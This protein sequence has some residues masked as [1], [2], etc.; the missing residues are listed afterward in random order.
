MD[1]NPIQRDRLLSASRIPA[2]VWPRD[3]VID[4]E[5]P[6][7]GDGDGDGAGGVWELPVLPRSEPCWEPRA[8]TPRPRTPLWWVGSIGGGGSSPVAGAGSTRYPNHA[9]PRSSSPN[10]QPQ[11]HGHPPQGLSHQSPSVER[12]HT[13]PVSWFLWSAD[14]GS[15]PHPSPAPLSKALAPRRR[16]APPPIGEGDYN[17]TITPLPTLPLSRPASWTRRKK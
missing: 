3:P 11:R 5:A 16:S 9:R 12:G 13:R 15:L 4:G 14:A 7:D 1:S 10:P 6:V 2:A 8:R 17:G